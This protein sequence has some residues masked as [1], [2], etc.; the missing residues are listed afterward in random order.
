MTS[1]AGM[2]RPRF[3]RLAAWI[4]SSLS[5]PALLPFGSLDSMIDRGVAARGIAHFP[6]KRLAQRT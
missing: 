5:L 2:T 3:R 1:C 4:S 6:R